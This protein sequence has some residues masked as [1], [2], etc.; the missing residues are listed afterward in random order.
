MPLRPTLSRHWFT[1][2]RELFPWLEEAL[3]PLGERYQ[4][5]VRVV[6]LV[7]VEESLPSSGGGRGRPLEDR[8]ALARAFPAKAVLDVPTT[9]VLVERLRTVG[10]LAVDKPGMGQN[11]FVFASPVRCYGSGVGPERI[12]ILTVA[13]E[14]FPRRVQSQVSLD[15]QSCN[16]VIVI[17][18]SDLDTC[19]VWQVISE[20]QCPLASG[21]KHEF[22]AG[23]A[24][25]QAVPVQEGAG[26]PQV[27][28][29]RRREPRSHRC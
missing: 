16:A 18:V 22:C 7:R 27:S 5:L 10:V 2:Q 12:G 20:V 25:G 23:G 29:R 17:T 14:G 4:G 1:F 6:E 8:A 13:L 21:A 19:K 15:S 9:R 24:G 11:Y 28:F 3:G 26:N